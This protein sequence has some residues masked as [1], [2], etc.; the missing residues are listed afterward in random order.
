M[1]NDGSCEAVWTESI[2]PTFERD[3]FELVRLKS[4][5]PAANAISRIYE[6]IIQCDVFI[7]TVFDKNPYVCLEIGAAIASGKCCIIITHRADVSEFFA[8][9]AEVIF[10][11]AKCDNISQNVK[12]AIVVAGYDIFSQF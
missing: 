1:P 3:H 6:E 2:E 10:V 7:A 5:A 9:A 12:R 11:K 4:I 8:K